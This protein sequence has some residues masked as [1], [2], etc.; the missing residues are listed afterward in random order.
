M[1]ASKPGLPPK[2]RMRH[3]RHF[4]DELTQRMGEGIGR[5]IR[6]DTITSNQDQPRASLGDLSDLVASI[7]SHGVL[8]PLLVRPRSG[9][10]GHYELVSGERRFHAALE[11]GLSEVPCIELTVNDH[12]AL[13]IALIENLQRKDL[14]PFE[15]ADGFATL[16]AKYSYTHEQV[17][18]A[19]GRSRVT[20][21]ET[22]R[23][24]QIPDDIREACRHAD[25]TAKGLLLE[26]AKAPD[27]VAMRALVDAMVQDALDREALRTLRRELAAPEG[28]TTT[29]EDID[30]RPRGDVP[31]RP[32]VFR[33]RHPER[34]FS[35]SLSFR[36]ADEPRPT[37]VI[38]ALEELI[39]QL[40]EQL[41]T[42]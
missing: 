15:E 16:V 2:K 13:E 26:I 33:F 37:D 24:R 11:A 5:M 14:T 4:V 38:A 21:T 8:E 6:A 35:V 25:I 1:A 7:T 29:D 31:P 30:E 40:R 10:P 9:A 19:V 3:D 32:H 18:N 36:T 28:T 41:E 20:V 12:Q 23:L 27:V 42:G 34:P 22:L 17:A 39:Q